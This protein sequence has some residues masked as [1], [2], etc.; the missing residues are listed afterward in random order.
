MRGVHG[1]RADSVVVLGTPSAPVY[2]HQSIRI[3]I[4]PPPA[5]PIYARLPI[6][7]PQHPW[8]VLPDQPASFRAAKPMLPA[9]HNERN[10]EEPKRE[11]R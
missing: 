2:P 3:R 7:T 10:R 5:R 9:S 6:S 8:I 11:S 1:M 4:S